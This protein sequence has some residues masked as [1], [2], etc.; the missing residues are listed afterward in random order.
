[1]LLLIKCMLKADYRYLSVVHKYCARVLAKILVATTSLRASSL[2]VTFNL[3]LQAFWGVMTCKGI[4][5]EAACWSDSVMVFIQLLEFDLLTCKIKLACLAEYSLWHTTTGTIILNDA[6]LSCIQIA[7]LF[8]F[9]L[10]Y[11]ENT[12]V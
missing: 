5:K 11:Q 4:F 8:E 10:G 6:T 1:M 12:V 2:S 9:Y 7:S 3:V